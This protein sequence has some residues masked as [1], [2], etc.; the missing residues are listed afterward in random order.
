M[1]VLEQTYDQEDGREDVYEGGWCMPGSLQPKDHIQQGKGTSNVAMGDLSQQVTVGSQ[2]V[3]D[4]TRHVKD[5][6]KK[7][8]L[9]TQPQLPELPTGSMT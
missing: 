1:D 8:L 3:E 5:W 7:K 9:C 2:G 4:L 6:Q